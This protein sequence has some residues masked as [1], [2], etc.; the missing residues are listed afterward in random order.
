[1]NKI[2]VLILAIDF[3]VPL[4]G[5]WS[6]TDSNHQIARARSLRL[7]LQLHTQ[8]VRQL[9]TLPMIAV[10]ASTGRIR[11]H[12]FATPRLRENMINRE[13]MTGQWLA[14]EQSSRFRPA[15]NTGVAI[16]HQYTFSAPVRL[17][18]RDVDV[19]TEC[20]D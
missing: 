1:M 19:S 20:D 10:V 11:P 5:I 9:I 18:A 17:S 16:P 3:D 15:V 2:S 4:P 14:L 12:I 7:P 13:V 6:G 8:L